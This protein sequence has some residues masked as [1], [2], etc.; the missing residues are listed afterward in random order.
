MLPLHRQS[1]VDQTAVCL[2]ERLATGYWK[3]ELPGVRQIASELGVSKNT[4]CAALRHIEAEGILAASGCGRRWRIL[5]HPTVSNRA[6]RQLRLGILLHDRLDSA[7][8]PIVL[9]VLQMCRDLES[10]GHVCVFMDKSLTEMHHDPKRISRMVKE[11]HADAWI[12]VRGSAEVLSWFANEGMRCFAIGGDYET[13]P[14]AAAGHSV[15]HAITEATEHLLALGHRR[16]VLLTSG[17]YRLHGWRDFV[18][19]FVDALARHGIEANGYHIPHWE[20]SPDGLHAILENLFRVTPPTAM[21]VPQPRHAHAIIAF[22]MS[23]G[24]QIPRDLSLIVQFHSHTLQWCRP[25]PAHFEWKFELLA[26]EAIHWVEKV[27]HGHAPFAQKH[28]Q[29]ALVPGGSIAP[30]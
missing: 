14:V 27:A 4:V 23:R 21:I 25:V 15:T 5:D 19:V 10:A 22:A 2:R 7:H 20:E 28:F 11:A 9:M 16:I 30:P 6:K 3:G 12:V 29:C 18:P 13:I 1:L 26:R 17:I 24:L 8:A